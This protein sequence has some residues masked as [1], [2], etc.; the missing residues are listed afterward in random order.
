MADDPLQPWRTWSGLDCPRDAPAGGGGPGQFRTAGVACTWAENEEKSP[1]EPLSVQ[2]G[3]KPEDS[4]VTVFLGGWYTISGYG[5]R[6]TWEQRFLQTVLEIQIK[7]P[8]IS[9]RRS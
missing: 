3:F 5:P 1:W 4:T 8:I 9:T 6:D 2:H 7:T